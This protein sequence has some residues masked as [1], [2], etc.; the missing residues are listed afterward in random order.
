MT[1]AL[2]AGFPEPEWRIVAE[3]LT[4]RELTAED[5]SWVLDQLGHYVVQDGEAGVAVYR[6]AHQ[7]LADHLRPRPQRPGNDGD[8]E[9]A[10][11]A[12]A[13][14]DHYARLLADGLTPRQ[15]SYLWLHVAEHAAAGG[16]AALDR[17]RQL[18]TDH[19]DLRPDLAAAAGTRS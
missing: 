8:P 1:W 6:L 12:V 11:V 16:E 18:A 10:T 13:L 9:A 4:G 19:P 7:A 15:P 3:A 14:L 5:I 17:L 2:G